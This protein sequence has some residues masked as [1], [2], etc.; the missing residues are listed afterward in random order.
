[1]KRL[2]LIVI[3]L[4]LPWAGYCLDVPQLRG[5]VNDYAQM[6]TPQ[7]VAN[8]DAS[9]AAFEQAESTQVVV[10]TIPSLAGETLE[11]FSIKL[12]EAWKIGHKGLDNGVIVLIAKQERKIRIEVGRGLEGKLTDLISGRIIRNEMAPRFKQGDTEGGIIA[13]TSAIMAAVKGEYQDKAGD[14]KEQATNKPRIV[15]LLIFLVAGCLGM[16]AMSKILGALLGTVGL[17]A[18]IHLSY[19]GFTY[20]VLALFGIAGFAGA[21]LLAEIG[22]L[23]RAGGGRGGG[24]PGGRELY[25]GGGSGGY[26]G[27]SGGGSSFG[28]GGGDFGGGGASGGW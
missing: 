13:G 27:F 21:L 12:A 7:A 6:L 17:P 20:P 28:G 14:V 15:D 9:L 24:R 18:I 8:I 3:L 19:P 2:S 10:L 26:G 4:L 5:R 25:L 1:M 11:E 16:G 22:N 23:L